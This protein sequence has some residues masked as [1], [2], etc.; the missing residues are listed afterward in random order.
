M[1]TE[2]IPYSAVDTAQP[3]GSRRAAQLRAVAAAFADALRAHALYL[4][5][6][7]AFALTC[8]IVAA[9]T[10][11]TAIQ[12]IGFGG[13]VMPMLI[14]L[15]ATGRF[16]FVSTRT[17]WRCGSEEAMLVE[18]RRTWR[19]EFLDLRQLTRFIVVTLPAPVF[20]TTFSSFKRMIPYI[21]PYTWDHTFMR[22]DQMLHGGRAPWELLQPVLGYPLVTSTINTCYHAWIFVMF[23]TFI[24]QLWTRRDD[25]LRT[26]YL[27]AFQLCWIVL[28]VAVATGLAS[29]GPVYYGR[30]T[31]LE[32]P[33]IPL[34]SYL[35]AAGEHYP[36][37]ALDVQA[38][39]WSYYLEPV[40]AEAGRGISAMPSLHVA[41]SVLMVCLGWRVHRWAGIAYT[42][43]A[44]I[45]MIGSVHLGWHYAIDGYVSAVVIAVLWYGSGRLARWWHAALAR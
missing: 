31:G 6:I 13:K 33:F 17:A 21:T 29:G 14:L 40:G 26:Q 34:M 18:L 36:V 5:V 11:S 43:F 22:W 35:H 3:R 44:G 27:L 1:A 32:D 37:L 41:T 10:H 23:L 38:E 12:S 45:I 25:L 24:W 30:L 39:L 15:A 19:R 20:M 42:A 2:S 16:V 28:G 8:T 4:T 9:R 7:A